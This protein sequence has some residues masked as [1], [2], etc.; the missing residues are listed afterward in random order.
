MEFT[1]EAHVVVIRPGFSSIRA[2][3]NIAEG[4]KRHFGDDCEG[5]VE[6]KRKLLWYVEVTFRTDVIAQEL[7]KWFQAQAL[8]AQA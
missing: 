5:Y 8:D 7:L 2:A 1:R 4:A 3:N 6:A